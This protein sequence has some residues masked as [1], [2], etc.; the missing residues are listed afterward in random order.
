MQK[1]EFDKGVLYC[2][3]SLDVYELWNSPVCIISDGPYGVDGFDG[4]SRS[5]KNLGEVYAPI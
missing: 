3:N 4:D 5:Y 2:G 1:A